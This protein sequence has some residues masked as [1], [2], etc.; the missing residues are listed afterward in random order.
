M[1][2][3]HLPPLPRVWRRKRNCRAIFEC[4][5]AP[6]HRSRLRLKVLVFKTIRDMHHFWDKGMFKSHPGKKCLGIVNTLGY[7]QTDFSKGGPP[8]GTNRRHYVDPRYFAVMGL[9]VTALSVEYTTHEIVHAAF[10]YAN[11]VGRSAAIAP[12]LDNDEELICYPA[13]R[14]ARRLNLALHDA[15]MYRRYHALRRFH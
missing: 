10:A 7:H 14:M 1:R 13:G 6:S 4:D 8:E 5:L 3:I 15:G 9:S 2:T 11:R 12:A